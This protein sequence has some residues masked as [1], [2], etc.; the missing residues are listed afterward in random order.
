MENRHKSIKTSTNDPPTY[1]N[2]Y[3]AGLPVIPITHHSKKNFTVG[4]CCADMISPLFNLEGLES[5]CE[6]YGQAVIYRGSIP[7][8]PQRF[9]QDKHHSI[10]G[11]RLGVSPATRCR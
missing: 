9:E 1:K 5:A 4:A 3:S 8:H 7:G 2:L 10:E 11:S 6:D